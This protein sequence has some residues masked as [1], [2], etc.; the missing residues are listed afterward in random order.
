MSIY[1]ARTKRETRSGAYVRHASAT[2]TATMEASA[3]SE[4]SPAAKSTSTVTAS[5]A[6][7]RIRPRG[8]SEG[9]QTEANNAKYSFCFHILSSRQPLVTA[10][11][12]PRDFQILPKTY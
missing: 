12:R 3:A 11:A 7:A 10:I 9:K 2:K 1:W 4:V 8:Q 5:A 6:A